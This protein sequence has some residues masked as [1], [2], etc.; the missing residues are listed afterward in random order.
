MKKSILAAAI[1]V[2]VVPAVDANVLITEIVENGN[3]KAVELY[4]NSSAPVDLSRYSLIQ[5]N[6]QTGSNPQTIKIALS[7]T[8]EASGVYVVA[9]SQLA[10]KLT[11]IVD[12]VEAL[13]FNGKGGDAVA[14]AKEGRN[15]DLIGHLGKDATDVFEDASL[16]RINPSTPSMSFEASDWKDA[17][18]G[19]YDGLGNVDG[20]APP[21]PDPDPNPTPDPDP[22][23]SPASLIG[24]LQGSSWASPYT[25]PLNG[26]FVSDEVFTVIGVI[27]AIQSNEL[28][29]GERLGF[30][31]QDE[32]PD[33]DARTSDGIFVAADVSGLK[34]GDK[35]EVVGPVEEYYGWT[36]IPAS[37]IKQV[38]T[39]SITAADLTELSSDK[40]FDFTLER[41]EGMLININSML[42]MRVSRSYSLDEGPQRYN[43]VLSK[44]HA[45][46][47]PNQKFFP[48]SDD[49]AKTADCNEDYRLVVESFEKDI[50]GLPSWYPDFA[51]SDADQNGSTEDYIRVG[52]RANQLQGVLGYSY[53]DYR[54]YVT[55]QANNGTFVTNGNSRHDKPNLKSGDIKLATFNTGGYFN[56]PFWGEAN[57]AN[58]GQLIESSAD[59]T[60]FEVQ[61]SKLVNAL[62]GLDADIVGLVEVENNGLSASSAI[63]HLVSELNKNLDESSH[64]H[65]ASAQGLEQVGELVSANYLIFKASKVG[66]ESLKVADMPKQVAGEIIAEQAAS[67]IATFNF[68]DRDEVLTVAVSD[69]VDKQQTCLEDDSESLQGKCAELR[70]SAADYLGQ[71]LQ[72]IPGEKVILG[73]LNAFLNE[74]PISV[75]TN[76]NAVPENYEIK[77][78]SSTF[79]AD[80][81]LQD[82]DGEVIDIQYGYENVLAI[83]DTKGYNAVHNDGQ[84]SL[85]YI[86]TSPGLKSLV[87]DTVQWN[88][89]AAES[90][91]LAYSNSLGQQYQDVYRAAVHDP[92]VVSIAFDGKPLEPVDPIYP[93]DPSNPIVPGTPIELPSEPIN[94]PRVSTPVVG[95]SFKHFVDLTM[96]N[97]AYLKVGDEVSVSISNAITSYVATSSMVAKDTLD[98]FEIALGWT[99]VNFAEGLE[100]GEYSV[101][102]TIDGETIATTRINVVEKADNDNEGAGSTGLAGWL[103]LLGLG[104]LRRKFKA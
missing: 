1:S 33:N 21:N 5:Y 50:V 67:V 24:E 42:E 10:G 28:D 3:D 26:K 4:N 75:L 57:L 43:M 96:A 59:L 61:T 48:S 66:L 79:V 38:G 45:S 29:Q 30:Y 72:A 31:M 60:Q 65:I 74:D 17:G 36:Q 92:V 22:E 97:G 77:T 85:D 11:S 16:Q 91:V 104:F 94:E 99:E 71:Q 34:V 101:R 95:Q 49:A 87:V 25:D 62:I 54:L 88:I 35:V 64:Y 37:Q 84:G 86:L 78:A 69:F 52:D 40:E 68:K 27:T 32:V 73:S 47:H 81:P 44:G 82:E 6:N 98:E 20:V 100:L 89:N 41:H 9:H 51:K 8:L 58:G 55:E 83:L 13:A 102:T 56:S 90:S 15:I 19:N 53:S 18:D 2:A 80:M 76:R 103:A 23:P 7:G 12:Q 93:P 39:G 46:V 63:G 14:L 70:V